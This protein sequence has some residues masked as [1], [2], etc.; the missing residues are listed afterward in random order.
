MFVTCFVLGTLGGIF[1]QIS[2]E[3]DIVREKAIKFLNHSAQLLLKEIFHPNPDVEMFLFQEI[4]KVSPVCFIIFFIESF[5][6]R[7]SS[8]FVY[9]LQ[10]AT[11][12]LQDDTTWST[13]IRCYPVA[14]SG[15]KCR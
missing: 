5:Q 15:N 6:P 14:I 4:K 2:S 3:D 11:Q 7:S 9:H 8:L 10:S 1:S 13:V 12:N